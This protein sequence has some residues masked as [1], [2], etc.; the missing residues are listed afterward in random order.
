MPLLETITG[1][2]LSILANRLDAFIVDKLP[3][4]QR[5]TLWRA[6]RKNEDIR[7]SVA[8]LYRI[9]VDG[10]YLLVKGNRIDQYQPVGGVRKSFPGAQS[11]FRNLSVRPDD[12]LTVDAVS[13]RDLRVRMPAKNLLKFLNWYET[14]HDREICQQREFKE[15]LVSP[16]YLDQ[17]LF[18]DVA[19]Q[20]LY[21]VPTWHYSQHF[22]CWELLY[23][24]VF[25]PLFT[26]KQEEAIR[27]LKK[28]SS[29]DYKWVGE[30]RIL[31]LGRDKPTRSKPFQIGEHA[32]LL[33]SKDHKLF[34][35]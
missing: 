13:E 9:V 3:N 24:E 7:V 26:L 15:E 28:Q 34:H 11:T 25:E 33:I 17:V 35:H 10:D 5:L 8:Y 16:G 27:E 6:T 31:A 30:E 19:S 32:Q 20:Y 23:H 22:R 1:V 21:T 4:G 18:A 14:K 2:A 12:N 29:S